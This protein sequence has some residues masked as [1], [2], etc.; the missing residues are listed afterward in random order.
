MGD[1][2][3]R[4]AWRIHHRQ[5]LIGE[6]AIRESCG[7]S[8]HPKHDWELWYDPSLGAK[9]HFL[10][11]G[12]FFTNPVVRSAFR[13]WGY[14]PRK[15]WKA[16][17]ALNWISEPDDRKPAAFLQLSELWWYDII[18]RLKRRTMTKN[19]INIVN[20]WCIYGPW[21]GSLHT[22]VS[23]VRRHDVGWIRW[24]SDG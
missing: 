21:A 4:K 10:T 16:V 14:I 15:N 11:W 5:C 19:M 13:S 2:S 12:W 17:G 24:S 9:P 23:E 1:G 3:H 20:L 8:N 18:C 7:D 6:F 22:G